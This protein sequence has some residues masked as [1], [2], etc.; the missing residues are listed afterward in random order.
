[1]H[2]ELA[3]WVMSRVKEWRDYRDDN[4]REKWMEYDF[5]FTRRT[6]SRTRPR[7]HEK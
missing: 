7:P 3:G 5:N 2:P 1:M 6:F 4:Y